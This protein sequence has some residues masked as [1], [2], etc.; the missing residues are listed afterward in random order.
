MAFKTRRGKLFR[1][2]VK[3]RSSMVT[4]RVPRSSD[5]AYRSYVPRVRRPDFG[6]PD[7]MVTKLR[8]VDTFE[9]SGAAGVLGA[10]VFRMNSCYDPDASGLGHQ[11]Y[12]FDQLCGAVGSGPYAR[13]R[14]LGSRAN[15]SFMIKTA[16]SLAAANVG[17]VIVGLLTTQTNGL[18]GASASSLCEASGSRW[19]FIGDKGGGENIKK[20]YGTYVPSRD[21]GLDSG[22]DTIAAPYNNNPSSQ[23][24]VIPWKVD[25]VG[26]AVVTALVEIEYTVEFF[27][28][29]EVVQS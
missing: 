1:K 17:P 29:N 20:L 16:P 6:F 25:T 19:A 7:K 27:D 24:Y 4:R 18:F 23:F 10:N 14:V 11:P 28:R 12:Y 3:S 8:Y 15:V 26:A 5:A 21:L 22:D 13:Y 9:L 2:N